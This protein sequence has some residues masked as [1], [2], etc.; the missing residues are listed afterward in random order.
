MLRS[1]TN[2]QILKSCL[3]EE[4][5]NSVEESLIPAI[6]EKW[7]SA[8]I[9]MYEDLL[10]SELLISG[11]WYY[12]LTVLCSGAPK[13]QWISWA[14]TPADFKDKN[15]YAYRGKTTLEFSL[16]ER[17]AELGDKLSDYVGY[18]GE[19]GMEIS[20][21]AV[22][23]DITFLSGRYS[24]RFVDEMS[25]QITSKVAS[26]M[27]CEG[28]ER[29]SLSLLLA[30]APESYFEHTS[31]NVTYRRLLL[32]DKGS[33][34]RDFWVKWTRLNSAV[35]YSVSDDVTSSDVEFDLG[36][37]VPQKIREKEYRFL[38]REGR[39]KYQNA[40]GRKCVTEWREIIRRAIKR[41]ELQRV[42]TVTEE[43]VFEDDLSAKLK[44]ILG[45]SYK[46][47]EKEPVI[48]EAPISDDYIKALEIAKEFVGEK[49]DE[50]TDTAD[51]T[52]IVFPEAED[53]VFD[54]GEGDVAEEPEEKEPEENEEPN[55][56]FDLPWLMPDEEDDKEPELEIAEEKPVIE[57]E[58]V[59]EEKP[60]IEE[61]PV[62]EEE[63]APVEEPVCGEAK[64]KVIKTSPEVS[65]NEE[66]SPAV[67]L[68]E[69]E[70]RAGELSIRL[71]Y[72]KQMRA[73]LEAEIERL[74]QNETRLIAENEGL[75]AAVKADEVKYREA[76]E[77]FKLE[78]ARLTAQNEVLARSEERQKERLATAARDAVERQKL[79][80]E[81]KRRAEEERARLA[82]EMEATPAPTASPAIE[83]VAE[84]EAEPIKE[85]PIAP[86]ADNYTYVSKNVKLLFRRPVDPNITG[87]I[88]EIIKATLEYFGKEKI[89]LRIKASVPDSETVN[90][91][92]ISIP[93][94]EMQLLSNIIQVLGSSGLGIAKAIVE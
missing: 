11:R 69:A 58:P 31:E 21:E 66:T 41:G 77:R 39:D 72:E 85:T 61:A 45:D 23:R 88:Y 5:L 32:I 60:V 7:G 2:N 89:N 10:R 35:G 62:I 44:D 22:S 14:V 47:A 15:P 74:R 37:D 56:V 63:P 1:L 78:I 50:P 94:E 30:F 26:L 53:V 16:C 48:E 43:V 3:S 73:R 81:E 33:Q 83:P 42:E 17:P 38:L 67:A 19:I 12:P 91:E 64:V 24:Q 65:M 20:V 51:T 29:S 76:E 71:E 79:L 84:P 4:F 6:E 90:L 36:E 25:R 82:R 92:F 68:R 57:Q 9:F 13:T 34:P 70:A 46:P 49:Q 93:M 27:S 59:I 18:T 75:R 28:L 80:E 52:E 8:D 86:E 87:R 40:M 55:G 54:L